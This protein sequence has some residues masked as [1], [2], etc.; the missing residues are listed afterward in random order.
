MKKISYEDHKKRSS[1]ENHP[2]WNV[3]EFPHEANYWVYHLLREGRVVYVGMTRDGM[4]RVWAHCKDKK[5]DSFRVITCKNMWDA[6]T[7]EGR[8]IW[9][10][11]PEYN[12][13]GAKHPDYET[14]AYFN[15]RWGK[16][17]MEYLD[18]Q[19]FIVKR[20]VKFWH[21]K[22]AFKEGSKMRIKLEN[23][24]TQ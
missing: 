5:F 9:E 21:K 24:E 18:E 4:C 14:R 16:K 6:Q 7:I 22:Y 2:V 13:K 19:P 11:D 23:L 8:D 10:F 20:G 12:R 1:Y 3:A 17:P 15:K